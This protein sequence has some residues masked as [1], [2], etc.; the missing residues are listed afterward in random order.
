MN[1]DS[2]QVH[3]PVRLKTDELP[4]LSMAFRSVCRMWVGES[5]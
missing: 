1:D 4:D 2:I 5:S 3:C